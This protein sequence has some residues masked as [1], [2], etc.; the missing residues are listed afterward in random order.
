MKVT[1]FQD[2]AWPVQ[3]VFWLEWGTSARQDA[4][5]QLV[6]SPQPVVPERLQT[7]RPPDDKH[8]IGFAD[9]TR[10]G[11]SQQATR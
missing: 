9:K 1:D 3:A 2:G 6:I 8:R 10:C 4:P 5:D 11:H 7:M